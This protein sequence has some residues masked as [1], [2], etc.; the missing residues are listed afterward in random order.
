MLR[1]LRKVAELTGQDLKLFVAHM[2][3]QLFE[4]P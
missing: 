3:I 2:S 1:N 4:P